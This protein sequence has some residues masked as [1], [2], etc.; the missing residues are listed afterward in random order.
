[1]EAQFIAKKSKLAS[2]TIWRILFCWLIFPVIFLLIDIFK[3]NSYKLEIFE[4][5]ILET[6]GVL[7]KNQKQTAFSG[8]VSVTINQTLFGR[9]FN[10]GNVTIDIVGK[11]DLVIENI[12]NPNDLKTFLESKIIKIDEKQTVHFA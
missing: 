7:S 9:F 11:N 10:Y 12:K 5:Q 1:M 2:V 3:L 6:Y 8:I 4:N